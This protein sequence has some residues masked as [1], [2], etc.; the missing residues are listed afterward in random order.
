MR[1]H[2]SQCDYIIQCDLIA[3]NIH[4]TPLK[5]HLP[6]QFT[7]TTK[8]I[9]DYGNG[10]AFNFVPSNL[11]F[12]G[13]FQCSISFRTHFH[14]AGPSAVAGPARITLPSKAEQQQV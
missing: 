8:V 12:C 4:Y 10:S 13:R 3:V 1:L 14:H 11:F 9:Y 2:K 6:C 7:A 5:Q